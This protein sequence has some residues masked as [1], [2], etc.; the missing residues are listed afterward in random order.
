MLIAY[1]IPADQEKFDATELR[2]RLATLLPSVMVPAHYITL[3]KMPLTPNNKVDLRALPVPETA[4][5]TTYRAPQTYTQQ[6][7][8]E[9]WQDTLGI[10][11]VGLDD[12]F[13][14]LGGHSL[15]AV[16]LIAA[17]STQFGIDL[18]VQDVFEAPVLSDLAVRVE[19]HMVRAISPEDMAA[20]LAEIG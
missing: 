20:L 19:E 16:P 4:S 15:R 6:T 11:Q 5:L 13:F 17:I 8:A 9:I 14:H 1:V 12:N 2:A 10:P 3:D 18:G 7:L